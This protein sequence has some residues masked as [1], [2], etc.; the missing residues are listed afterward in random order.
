M[1]VLNWVV[2]KIRLMF[3]II[4]GHMEFERLMVITKA[5][6]V[7]DTTYL[8]EQEA[9]ATGDGHLISYLV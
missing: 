2:I 7:L 5:S 3:D 9:N 6:T 1:L 8:D 4:L